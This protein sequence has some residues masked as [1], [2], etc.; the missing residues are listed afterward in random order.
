MPVVGEVKKSSRCNCS[1][2]VV[3]V[4]SSGTQAV[5]VVTTTAFLDQDVSVS[6]VTPDQEA[7]EEHHSVLQLLC[8]PGAR[9]KIND[10]VRY[11]YKFRQSSC[12]TA[13]IYFYLQTYVIDINPP[14]V[15]TLKLPSVLWAG[16]PVLPIKMELINADESGSCDF[17]WF[18]ST[19]KVSSI[20]SEIALLEQTKTSGVLKS[21]Q[22]SVWLH[23]RVCGRETRVLT[24]FYLPLTNL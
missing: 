23:V 13:L 4:S 6:V 1:N 17:E 10:Q 19:S 22:S 16:F 18:R 15:T 24:Y 8:T 21:L 14:E 11:N 7:A 20:K 5:A 3:A 2:F 12:F 9:L